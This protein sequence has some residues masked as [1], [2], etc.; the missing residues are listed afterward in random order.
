MTKKSHPEQ[1]ASLFIAVT[2]KYTNA[3]IQKA[4]IDRRRQLL[5][6]SWYYAGWS[7]GRKQVF[8]SRDWLARHHHFLLI[9]II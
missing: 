8:P 4:N 5:E 2:H 3:I 7:N 9:V 6:D 1:P